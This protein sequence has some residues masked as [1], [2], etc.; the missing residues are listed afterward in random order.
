MNT[1]PLVIGS[2]ASAL[3]VAQTRLVADFLAGRYP[4]RPVS[5]LTMKTTGDRI[6]DRKL[7]DIGGKGL[8]VKELDA[9]LL[10]GRTHY[11]VH[12]LKDMPMDIPGALP[13][14][15]CSRRE[16]PRDA[17]VLP[18]GMDEPDLSR[19][20]GT[21]SPRRVVQLEALFPG[22]RFESVRGNL[23]TRLRKLDEGQFG[24]LV[25]AAAGLKR[26]GLEGRISRYFTV[27]EIIP[28][29]G[30]GILAV[31]GGPGAEPDL[32]EGFADADSMT[33]AL[34]ERAFVRRLQGSCASPIAACAL[35]NDEQFTFR[36][37]Y[38][39]E[40]TGRR[41]VGRTHFR[42]GGAVRAAEAL[43][44]ELKRR[45]EAEEREALS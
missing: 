45:A 3:A 2:R 24:A 35:R 8:F 22:A 34:A 44:D 11:S 30:Q 16:D 19:P 43:A 10:E 14:V 18:E 42:E 26:L 9:A 27:D 39:H 7:D 41:Y 31:Q 29:A 33:A 17:L 38:W 6:L 15:C 32:F 40:A 21:S 20:I 5:I 25:L 36:G 4:E 23:Q 12:S 37:L 1:T 28:A 13:L